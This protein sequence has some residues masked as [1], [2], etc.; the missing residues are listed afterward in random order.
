M[1]SLILLYD[2]FPILPSLCHQRT[3]DH[4]H[5][6]RACSWIALV[7]RRHWNSPYWYAAGGHKYIYVVS[8]PSQQKCGGLQHKKIVKPTKIFDGKCS[9]K[10]MKKFVNCR[11]RGADNNN[12]I[13]ID[14]D[15]NL[16]ASLIKDEERKEH[17]TQSRKPGAR[18]GGGGKAIE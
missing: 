9:T 1:F 12:I 5:V 14:E 18:G 4:H 11:Y 15:I 10:L 13:H 8:K 17:T 7:W 16:N 2:I 6:M 3:R